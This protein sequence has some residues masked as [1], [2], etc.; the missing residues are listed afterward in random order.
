MTVEYPFLGL[1]HDPPRP[2]TPEE[3][4]E[5]ERWIARLTPPDGDLWQQAVRRQQARRDREAEITRLIFE[6]LPPPPVYGLRRLWLA[7]RERRGRARG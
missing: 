6:P 1:V 7:W 3:A 2:R 5:A 4:A